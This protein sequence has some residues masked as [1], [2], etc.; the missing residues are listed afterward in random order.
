VLH[1][2]TD[3]LRY[4]FVDNVPLAWVLPNHEQVVTGLPRGRYVVQWRT[5]LGDAVDAPAIVELP[6]R[7]SVGAAADAGRDR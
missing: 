2:G 6:A 3:T 1:N 7:S 5:F 4:A